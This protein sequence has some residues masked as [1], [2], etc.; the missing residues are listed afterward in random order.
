MIVA[1]VF[2]NIL[3]F[4]IILS[5]L[6][7]VHEMG[8]FLAARSLGVGVE[9]FSLGFGRT[10]WS[11][12]KNGTEYRMSALPFGGYVK[13]TG[14]D[15]TS[16]V[17]V[18]SLSVSFALKPVWARMIIVVAGPFSNFIMAVLV[19]FFFFMARGVPVSTSVIGDVMPD[20]P[21]FHAGLLPE[22]RI[23]S[24]NGEKITA[25]EEIS[26]LV[27]KT[28]QG[29]V[30]VVVSRKPPVTTPPFAGLLGA[31]PHHFRRTIEKGP[32]REV[33]LSISPRKTQGQNEYGEKKS[34][35]TIGIGPGPSLMVPGGPVAAIREAVG[36]TYTVC[37][38]TVGTVA[39][40]FKGTVSARE[41]IGGPITMARTTGAI[42]KNMDSD[43][44]RTLWTLFS[45]LG[46]LSASLGI[47]N[48]FP[49]PVLD[50][51]HLLFFVLEA[52]FRRPVS[53]RIR[54]LSTQ[55]GMVFLI[56]IMIFFVVNDVI[57]WIT[58]L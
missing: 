29:P 32:L 44:V 35:Y 19:F 40:I 51:G 34:R 26:P 3:I 28:G 9:V 4:L 23:V 48:L 52:V 1:Q 13:M 20:S 14:E 11:R 12:K 37:Y 58:G 41:T 8:H 56:A 30:S 49:I 16:E 25:W 54:E 39:R 57:R 24:I 27:Q 36:Q 38:L 55:A 31:A 18:E 7:F 2:F 10:L 6:V 42:T 15:P 50:G 22:D 5:I 33:A 21:A 17:S 53:L 46:L 43:L 47:I 45:F